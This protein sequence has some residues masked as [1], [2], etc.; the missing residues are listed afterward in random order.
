[1]KNGLIISNFAARNK[2]FM[3]VN[4]V[5]EKI[6]IKGARQHNL[7]NVDLELPKKK[8]I[9]VTG[10]SGSGKSSLCIDTLY[11]EG[12]RRYVESLSSY[13]RQF[14]DRMNK[15]DLDY[16]SGLCPAVAI[17]QNSGSR[18]GRSTVGTLTEIYDYLRL[19]Y[20]R[21]GKT[22]SPVSGN[23]V[24][25]H[26]V[27]DVTDYI[28]QFEDGCK[29]MILSPIK[30]QNDG[31]Q[32]LKL[33]LSK[34][35]TRIRLNKEM[36]DVESLLQ[37]KNIP[38]IEEYE[39]LIDRLVLNKSEENQS[40]MAD[41]VQ[42]A[43]NESY[44]E[45]LVFVLPDQEQLF[46]NRFELDGI[47]FEDPS[48]HFFNFNNSYGACKKCEGF[49]TVIGIDENLV[50]P[51]KSKSVYEEAIACWKGEKM[52][53]WLAQLVRNAHLFDFPVHKPIKQLSAD[54]YQLLWTGNKYFNGLNDFFKEIE[55]QAYKIQYRVLLSRYRGKTN[56]P[57][58]KGSRIR[59]DAQHVYVAGK[60]LGNLLQ[61]PL[62]ELKAYLQDI[63]LNDYEVAVSSRILLELNNRVQTLCRL[64]LGYLHLNRPAA[65]LSGGEAQRISLTRCIG[66]NLTESLYVLDEPSIGLHPK[67]NQRLIEVLNELKALGNTVLVIEHDE[68][69][70]RTADHL[71]DVGPEAG[72]YGGEIIFNDHSSKITQEEKSLTAQYLNKKLEVKSDVPR[73]KAQKFIHILGASEHNLKDINADFPLNC[74]TVV[75]G[76][77]GS[78]KTTLVK[79]ILYPAI[80]HQLD[81]FAD[82]PGNFQSLQGDYKKITA[83]EMIDQNPLGRSSRSNPVTYVKA[84][85]QIRDLFSQQ[86]LSKV[87]GYKPGFFSFN[88]EGG[89]CENC[90]GDG[91]VLIAMQFLA[92][93]R[94]QC[95]VCKG[96]RYRE[97]VLEV[98]YNGKN[99]F[100]VL[101]MSIDES[102]H[103]FKDNKDIFTKLKSLNDVGLGYL[104]LGQSIS[105]LSGGEAQ[106]V[107]LASYLGKGKTSEHIL[108]IFDEPTTGLHFH[109]I[110]KLLKAFNE[111]IE[112]GH[113]LVIIEHNIE[114]IKCADWII[115]LGPEG[116]IKGGHLVYQGEPLGILHSKE[117]Q[118]APFLINK[119]SS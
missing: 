2:S 54:E 110:N 68:E 18:A 76:V 23:V 30:A 59:K 60:N 89:R 1:M 22:I 5:P 67:D 34:G 55:N 114:I 90:K 103:F 39:I 79:D 97:D 65:T 25:R 40:R 56:C 47:S 45:C 72:V 98:T 118:T 11:A 52:S 71:V 87:R 83:V 10:V 107:K 31:K 112:I 35:Y 101:D 41:S 111:L 14:L 57:D 53:T 92:D 94:L 48:P 104:K 42:T 113:S 33:L 4:Q 20:A 13:A 116:G 102:L 6:F 27:S 46:N 117:S 17:D 50:I 63:Q 81:E 82:K 15:P 95:E 108:F 105:T 109:D 12:Q 100:E 21:I 85:D 38:K 93:V 44:G 64:G 36:L 99:I 78:G 61:M 3:P 80:N 88:V 24:A 106:R 69:I 19:L 119:I 75:T 62:D 37:S 66:S 84:F 26:Q 86:K 8:L 49:G 7:K 77:S 43:M 73:R 115:D 16:I 74:F 32:E 29:L 70:I 51:D 9:V 91:E 28:N 58:C 96:K